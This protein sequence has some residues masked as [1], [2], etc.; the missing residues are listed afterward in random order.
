[1]AAVRRL[2]EHIAREIK[3]VRVN[4]RKEDG[5]G[6]EKSVLAGTT[7]LRGDILDLAGV[8]VVARR[9]AAVDEIGV[10][11]I[12]GDVA[13]FF[14]ADGMPIAESNLPVVAAAGDGGGAALLL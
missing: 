10:K 6:A 11:R 8:A 1:M 5:S 4:R 9:F 13:I 12:G 14:N 2:K 3:N 7:R